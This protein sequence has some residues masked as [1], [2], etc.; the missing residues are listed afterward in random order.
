MPALEDH[1]QHSH[2]ASQ[3]FIDVSNE[4]LLFAGRSLDDDASTVA[5]SPWSPYT[6]TWSATLLTTTIVEDLCRRRERSR[7]DLLK[8]T[9]ESRALS[10]VKDVVLKRVIVL[11]ELYHAFCT[12]T[13][14]PLINVMPMS[15][16]TSHEHHGDRRQTGS[17]KGSPTV[18]NNTA[19]WQE[20]T[21][22]LRQQLLTVEGILP[23]ITALSSLHTHSVP[24]DDIVTLRDVV[25]PSDSSPGSG[26]G[27]GLSPP[28]A[29]HHASIQRVAA[30]SLQLLDDAYRPIRQILQAAANDPSQVGKVLMQLVEENSTNAHRAAI[31]HQIHERLTSYAAVFAPYLESFVPLVLPTIAATTDHRASREL[32][33][34][35]TTSRKA[36]TTGPTSTLSIEAEVNAF[37]A[38]RSSLS[39]AI[40]RIPPF[41]LHFS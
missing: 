39:T 12:L 41:K 19:W 4:A 23:T 11:Q 3:I 35:L 32:L 15:L 34:F 5:S 30:Q 36:Q 26:Q 27:K 16:P 13:A 25:D 38:L 37:Q 10:A 17:V 33:H 40:P 14:T 8:A 29:M 9:E 18:A 31:A 22:R 1:F 28:P 24:G 2:D 6:K 21:D 7:Q 20:A